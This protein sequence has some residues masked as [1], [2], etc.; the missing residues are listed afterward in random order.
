MKK[1]LAVVDAG[2]CLAA[3]AHCEQKAAA[4]ALSPIERGKSL[5]IIGGCHD[6]HTP[7]V[8]SPADLPLPDF[9]KSLSRHS[10]EAPYPTWKPSDLQQNNALAPT[11]PLLTTWAGPWRVSF[12]TNLTPDK[13]TG[14]SEWTNATS[15]QGMGTGKHQGQR[16]GRGILPPMPWHNVAQRTDSD[17]KTVWAYLLTLPS[18]QN[19]VPLPVPPGAPPALGN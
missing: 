15:L 3:V 10:A 18:S 12:A 13:E 6:C 7:K 2:V 5:V 11:N 16:N 4:I 14:I 17:F 1:N 9:T 8:M 19:Q